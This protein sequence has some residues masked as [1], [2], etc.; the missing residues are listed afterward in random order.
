MTDLPTNKKRL[1]EAG[2][3]KELEAQTLSLRA[4]RGL[5][6]LVL[7]LGLLAG[8]ACSIHES[9]EADDSQTEDLP[10]LDDLD[11]QSTEDF[12]FWNEDICQLMLPAEVD[13]NS[14]V[15]FKLT[16]RPEIMPLAN[17]LRLTDLGWRLLYCGQPEIISHQ[18]AE[19]LCPDQP[20]S[21]HCYDYRFQHVANPTY[22]WGKINLVA[23]S[24]NR[25]ETLG[26]GLLHLIYDYLYQLGKVDSLHQ[27]IRQAA[28]ADPE[29]EAQV[30]EKHP[31]ASRDPQ[32]VY[33][34]YL[35]MSELHGQLIDSDNLPEALRQH[36]N[37]FFQSLEIDDLADRIGLTRLGR[38][39]LDEASVRIFDKIEHE[40]Y[41]CG[42]EKLDE[43]LAA[44]CHIARRIELGAKDD[45]KTIL[46]LPG[47]INLLAGP[48]AEVSLAHELMHVTYNKYFNQGEIERINQL[49]EKGFDRHP[50][51]KQFLIEDLKLAG[52]D[53]YTEGYAYLA[54]WHRQLPPELEN[55]YALF[56]EDRPVLVD[57]HQKAIDSWSASQANDHHQ[58]GANSG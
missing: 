13:N 15:N 21:G 28:E 45:Q 44:G 30:I 24:K 27:A 53:I 26:H 2:H 46:Y 48:T 51:L 3:R 33:G 14:E 31:R 19:S 22:R 37:Q 10:G 42:D 47:Q 11:S 55:N 6:G 50:E 7:S 58:A 23:E 32:N 49:V 25:G 38:D 43:G 54:H 57:F 9:L 1:A 20:E 12:R 16:F 35:L 17:R 8:S 36:Y 41:E 5:G 34:H 4:R 29:I 40:D 39:L 52:T 56:F 18:D